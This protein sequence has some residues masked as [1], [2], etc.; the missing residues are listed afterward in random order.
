ML[1]QN[2]DRLHISP[3]LLQR[4]GTEHRISNRSEPFR[5]VSPANV[6]ECLRILSVSLC[7]VLL[8]P[9]T[10][11]RAELGT[12]FTARVHA[13]VSLAHLLNPCVVTLSTTATWMSVFSPI[14][15]RIRRRAQSAR[16]LELPIY[17]A[18][19]SQSA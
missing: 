14:S 2:R 11:V 7:G 8:R 12:L 10:S 3:S 6:Y 15:D 5:K 18:L 13:Q 9:V 19:F 17:R 16:P 4:K 1:C